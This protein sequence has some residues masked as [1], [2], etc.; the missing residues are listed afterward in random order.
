[1]RMSAEDRLRRDVIMDLMCRDG[2]RFAEIG[3]R[4]GVDFARHFAAELERMRPLQDDGLVS[5][6]AGGIRVTAAGRL[7]LRPIAMVF[8]AYLAAAAEGAPRRHSAAI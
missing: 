8:D 6:D 7:L 5:R 4:H 2:V 1:L 3:A